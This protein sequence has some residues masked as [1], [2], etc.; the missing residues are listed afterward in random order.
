MEDE[1]KHVGTIDHSFEVIDLRFFRWIPRA[2]EASIFLLH[3][4]DFGDWPKVGEMIEI[5]CRP[6]SN[7]KQKR[8]GGYVGHGSFSGIQGSIEGFCYRGGWLDHQH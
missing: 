2:A 7:E 5:H 3:T 8:S 6:E 1:P 4:W